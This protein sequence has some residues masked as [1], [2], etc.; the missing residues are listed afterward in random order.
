MV[1]GSKNRPRIDMGVIGQERADLTQLQILIIVATLPGEDLLRISRESRMMEEA[2][3]GI[4]WAEVLPQDVIGSAN[5]KSVS[6]GSVLNAPLRPDFGA[7]RRQHQECR[8][9]GEV[10]SIAMGSFLHHR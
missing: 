3:D 8:K 4:V 9:L 6:A 2:P 1:E 10:R 7:A 5:L